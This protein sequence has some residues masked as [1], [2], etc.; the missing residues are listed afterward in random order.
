MM[1]GYNEALL[2]KVIADC[3]ESLAVAFIREAEE[4]RHNPHF[5]VSE[6]DVT[7]FM[8]K[9]AAMKKRIRPKTVLLVAAILILAVAVTVSTVSAIETFMEERTTFLGVESISGEEDINEASDDVS[10]PVSERMTQTPTVVYQ[11]KKIDPD[12]WM[13]EYYIDLKT[14][15]K[16]T[17]NE[18]ADALVD[19]LYA[20]IDEF[21]EQIKHGMNEKEYA[22]AEKEVYAI[23][24]Q[25][26]ATL[27]TAGQTRP[28]RNSSYKYADAKIIEIRDL[29]DQYIIDWEFIQWYEK[30]GNNPRTRAKLKKAY[31]FEKELETAEEIIENREISIKEANVLV[32]ELFVKWMEVN[33]NVGTAATQ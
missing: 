6:E 12:A 13:K 3:N 31:E 18:E 7:A 21:Y 20:R 26:D 5:R 17:G 28:D 14:Q 15:Y 1:N 11:P 10:E 33:S 2:K 23:A 22:D 30:N 27:R 29:I 4:A 25:I 8:K 24:A 32:D 9:A 16:K 19:K